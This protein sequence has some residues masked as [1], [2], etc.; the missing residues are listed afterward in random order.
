[1]QTVQLKKK[2]KEKKETPEIEKERLEGKKTH[3]IWARKETHII[4]WS[5]IL[6]CSFKEFTLFIGISVSGFI[7]LTYI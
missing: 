5:I 3:L 2:K 6:L 7:F 4:L 1:M